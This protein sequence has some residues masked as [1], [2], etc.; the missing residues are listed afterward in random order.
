[1]LPHQKAA[2]PMSGQTSLLGDNATMNE[3]LVNQIAGGQTE[4]VGR[5]EFQFPS[6][7]IIDDKLRNHE[8]L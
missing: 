3:Q 2:S 7:L 4:W 6:Q 5:I 8:E 1:M